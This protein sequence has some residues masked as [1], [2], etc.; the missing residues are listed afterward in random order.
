MENKESKVDDCYLKRLEVYRNLLDLL[1]KIAAISVGVYEILFIFRFHFYI[2]DLLAKLG[3]EIPI[4]QQGFQDKQG[5]AFVL[6]MLLLIAFLRYPS[7]IKEK[8]VVKVQFYDYILIILGLAS[9]FYMF[10]RYPAF[11]VYYEVYKWDI[12]FGLIAI[13]LV[14]EA[15]RR[16]LGWILP[17]IVLVFLVIGIRDTNYNW[18][19]FVQYLYLDQGIFGI[20]FFVM[21]IYVFA[22]IFF[23]AFLLKIGVSDYMTQLMISIFGTRP[24]GPAKSA[25]VSSALMG[26][27][28]GSSVANVLTTGTFTIPLMKKAGYP[29]EIAGAVEPVASTGG[30]LMP[31][32]MGAAAFIMAQFLG[33]PYNKIII[34]AVI[35]ALVYY[36][37]VYIFIDLETKKL[38][39]RGLPKEL[40]TPV[41]YFVRKLYLML[42][43][44]VITVALVWGISPHIAAISCLGIAIWVAWVS[45]DNIPGNEKIYAGLVILTTFLMFTEDHIAKEVSLIFL[46]FLTLLILIGL[47][48]KKHIKFNEKF[49]I[50]LLFIGFLALAK[51]MGIKKRISIVHE[52]C[53]WNSLVPF[54]RAPL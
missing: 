30:Q 31:P 43:I 25:V 27:V 2:Y 45:K 41:R 26:T 40:L 23:G 35:P 5:M 1:L 9:M 8:Y 3:I 19:R 49:F 22:F 10:V 7:R 36:I 50:S 54:H 38:G 39:L 29:P 18:G 28:S 48:L 46:S 37:G 42:P 6:G 17:T 21:T 13:A 14:L 52:W 15:T 34:A 32:I 51:H 11:T 53:I 24:G 20:P 4:L 47:F 12:P 33:I 44:V 16:S